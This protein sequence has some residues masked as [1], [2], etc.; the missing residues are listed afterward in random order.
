VVLATFGFIALSEIVL[1]A[2]TAAPVRLA[3]SMLIGGSLGVAV[4]W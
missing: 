1:L 4:C 2:Q 3:V